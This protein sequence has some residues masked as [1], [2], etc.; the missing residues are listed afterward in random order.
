MDL[1]AEC[2]IRVWEGPCKV[3][4]YP[5]RAGRVRT[6]VNAR[7]GILGTWAFGLAAFQME[8]GH[9]VD[10]AT[11]LHVLLVQIECRDVVD[12]QRVVQA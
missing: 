3:S 12:I 5:S 6:R 2:R 9:A 7:H 10:E 4:H 8:T 1:N 11:P